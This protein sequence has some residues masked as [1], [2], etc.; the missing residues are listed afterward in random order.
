MIL[1]WLSCLDTQLF[2]NFPPLKEHFLAFVRVEFSKLKNSDKVQVTSFATN[3]S[4]F[5]RFLNL[6]TRLSPSCFWKA[7]AHK[8]CHLSKHSQFSGAAIWKRMFCFGFF[9]TNRNFP[10][11]THQTS[12]QNK[13]DDESKRTSRIL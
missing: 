8:Y 7:A 1:L 4:D 6:A 9:T 3:S 2:E 11:L 10:K 5:F 13:Y 12:N